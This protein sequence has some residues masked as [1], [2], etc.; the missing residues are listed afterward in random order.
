MS[1]LPQEKGRG[2][3]VRLV[4]LPGLFDAV[5]PTRSSTSSRGIG[6]ATG[7]HY[8]IV[9]AAVAASHR[10]AILRSAV[11]EDCGDYAHLALTKQGLRIDRQLATL[12]E[13]DALRCPVVETPDGRA[14]D[15]C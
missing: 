1:L 4:C 13:A 5:C 2:S 12:D 8:N 7:C 10:T 11:S 15:K 14:P 6:L 3:R 9:A